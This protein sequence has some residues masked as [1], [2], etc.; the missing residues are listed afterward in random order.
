M[1]DK[2][3]HI[4]EWIPVAAAVGIAGALV[5]RLTGIDPIGI[6]SMPLLAAAAI[7]AMSRGWFVGWNPPARPTADP[8]PRGLVGSQIMYRGVTYTVL[9]D[10]G[11]AGDGRRS[12]V[13]AADGWGRTG[14]L[15]LGFD[16]NGA[17][18]E[19]RVDGCD[20][21]PAQVVG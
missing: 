6:A 21:A 16:R 7:G 9:D 8:H 12:S 13:V 19:A 18:V 5:W 10:S 14:L 20:W 2:D 15:F 1:S 17:V 11:L 4:P 3:T